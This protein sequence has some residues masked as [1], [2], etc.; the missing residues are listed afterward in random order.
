M[1]PHIGCSD[2][3]ECSIDREQES[4]PNLLWTDIRCI[5]RPIGC[6]PIILDAGRVLISSTDRVL[7]T[8]SM[9]PCRYPSSRIETIHCSTT[10]SDESQRYRRVRKG[11]ESR[12]EGQAFEYLTSPLSKGWTSLLSV[13]RCRGCH[14]CGIRNWPVRPKSFTCTVDLDRFVE[15]RRTNVLASPLFGRRCGGRDTVMDVLLVAGAGTAF[16][17]FRTVSSSTVAR[18]VGSCS[19]LRDGYSYA[20]LFQDKNISIWDTVYR[21]SLQTTIVSMA[22]PNCPPV[23]ILSRLIVSLQHLHRRQIRRFT[24]AQRKKVDTQQTKR[25]SEVLEVGLP[26][27]LN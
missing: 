1:A 26:F 5:G 3:L 2:T 10:T 9:V 15:C 17:G 21:R 16:D 23:A 8:R 27:K 6:W 22:C 7:P 4:Y 18:I 11:D 25:Q 20:T 24:D 14:G 12:R 13:R 19:S